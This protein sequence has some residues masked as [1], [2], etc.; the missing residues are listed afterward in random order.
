MMPY[1][2]CKAKIAL[3]ALII[4]HSMSFVIAEELPTSD[5][6]KSEINLIHKS[7]NESLFTYKKLGLSGLIYSI[8]KCYED[9]KSNPVKCAAF[10]FTGY[11]IDKYM[12]E[13]NN[14]PIDEFF[15]DDAINNRLLNKDKLTGN[16]FSKNKLGAIF[17]LTIISFN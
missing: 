11:L 4:F 16:N 10:D 9:T 5:L 6:T 14:F 7:V 12:A 17:K 1:S 15:F 8:K 13:I 2:V 3:L